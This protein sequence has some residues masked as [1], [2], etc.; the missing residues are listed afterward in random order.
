[1]ANNS[2]LPQSIS[3]DSTKGKE[4][5]N[6]VDTLPANTGIYIVEVIVIDPTTKVTT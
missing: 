3:L 6:V 5:I 2:T 1:M 4:S